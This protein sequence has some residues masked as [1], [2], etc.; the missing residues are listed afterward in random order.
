EPRPRT[1]A[2][3]PQ[4]VDSPWS[5]VTSGPLESWVDPTNFDPAVA[6]GEGQHFTHLLWERQVEAGTGRCFH[7]KATRV[8]TL[9]AVRELSQWSLD[10]DVRAQRL[11]LHWLRVLRDGVTIDHLRQERF[12]WLQRET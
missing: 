3:M 4:V 8:E 9:E 5:R 11:T 12:R 6:A 10:L 2:A 1:S 7:A